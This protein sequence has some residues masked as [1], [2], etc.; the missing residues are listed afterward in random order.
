MKNEFLKSLLYFT[1]RDRNAIFILLGLIVIVIFL[2]VLFP[3]NEIRPEVDKVLQAQIDSIVR[4][5]H[6]GEKYSNNSY[7]NDDRNG[8]S[9]TIKLEPFRFD[10]NTLSEKGWLQMGLQERTVQILMNYRNKGGR[11]RKPEDLRKIYSLKEEEA[12]ALIP[13]VS[14]EGYSDKSNDNNGYEDKPSRKKSYSI[15]DIN[16]ASEEEWKA[17]PGIGDVL[18]K[19]IVKFRN[20]IGGFNSIDDVKR[21]YGLSDSTFDM[22]KPYLRFTNTGQ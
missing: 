12:N 15:V 19:R 21:T 8:Q 9:A 3:K 5:Q 16:T 7:K 11:F 22:I 1:K 17:L 20:S 10:P 4:Y 14:I 18:S 6:Q 13:F 2:P